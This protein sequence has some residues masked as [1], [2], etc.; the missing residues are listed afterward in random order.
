[1]SIDTN[2]RLKYLEM[3]QNIINRMANNSFLIKGWTITLSLAG[4]SLFASKH[5][6]IYLF[7]IIFSTIIFWILDGYYLRQEK[8]FRSLYESNASEDNYHKKL[9][10]LSLDTSKNKEKVEN[11]LLCMF[12]F[13]TSLIY[14]TIL[15]ITLLVLNFTLCPRG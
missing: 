7:L 12:S 13:P 10:N 11:I 4:F 5:E 3:I 6:D 14:I 15:F 9:R 2:D 1:M 8:L